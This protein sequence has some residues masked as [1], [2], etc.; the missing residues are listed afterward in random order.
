[1]KTLVVINH[2]YML[3]Q[4]R[5]EMIQRLLD[6]GEVVISTPFVGH[7]HDFE[8]M[9]CRCIEAVFDRHGT[10][11]FQDLK[12]LSYYKKII[13]WEKPDLV[14]TYSIKPNLY[15]GMVCQKNGIPYCA[16]I[17]GLGSAFRNKLI[18]PLV[19]VMHRFA[20]RN[21]KKVFFENESN[22]KLFEERRIIR[23]EQMVRLPGAGVNLQYYRPQPY[24]DEKAGLH[25]LYLGRI[26]RDKGV[27]EFLDV[28]ERC[29]AE[30]GD[31]VVFDMVGFHDG[32][33]FRERV[34]ALHRQGVIVY[35]GFQEDPRPFYAAAHCVV[36]P[37]Y[38]EGMSNVLLEAASTER[39]L[40]TSDIPGC[41]E[42]V[43]DG[44]S[45]LLIR[46]ESSDS[47]YDAV[48]RFAARAPEE[49]AGMGPRGRRIMEERFD[50]KNVVETTL[51]AIGLTNG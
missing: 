9:G 36:L 1:M 45:G 23:P 44:I 31:R 18:S 30:L 32:D 15:A 7:E 4:M 34:N 42:A 49:R 40:I 17:T 5:R 6:F 13:R 22:A 48:K 51:W 28:A 50:R 29:R 47:L 38:H 46:P 43:E 25:F 26:M 24:P 21:A 8:N 12:L 16:N 14:I 35:H 3:W 19:T 10:D 2:S 41:R 39:A 27:G 37:S 33:E 20:L 11:P